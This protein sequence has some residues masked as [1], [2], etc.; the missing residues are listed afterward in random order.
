MSGGGG[1]FDYLSQLESLEPPPA[2][3][4]PD[5]KKLESEALIGEK[6]L[7]RDGFH[8][9]IARRRQQAKSGKAIV[10]IV[11]DDEDTSALAARA[12]QNGGYG[13]VR[14][15]D[16]AET[17]AFLK[18]F[19]APALMLL[20]VNLPN[21]YN[22]FDMLRHLRAHPTLSSIPVVM[23]T[24]SRSREDVVRGLTFGADGYVAKPVTAQALRE[25]VDKVL[26]G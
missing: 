23:F 16:A 8:V 1:E 5:P 20:D 21:G 24:A 18:R 2:P 15:K 14:A 12:L 11:E 17:A 19:G 26:G 4:P 13:T 9:V 6:G 10:L 22:G 3:P 7:E 25:V